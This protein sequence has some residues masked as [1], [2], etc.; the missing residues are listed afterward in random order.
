MDFAVIRKKFWF[1]L[2]K[3][4]FYALLF[5]L[6]CV[7]LLALAMRFTGGNEMVIRI[8]NCVIRLA[9]AGVCA[10][11]AVDGEKGLIKGACAGL[12][13]ALGVYLLF[14]IMGGGF[15]VDGGEVVNW[16]CATVAGAL[17]GIIFVNLKNKGRNS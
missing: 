5:T 4:L 1:K 7:L 12:A 16:A 6:V 15:A 9:A 2:I 14:G 17:F 3:G 10:F 11:F 13:T 8:V